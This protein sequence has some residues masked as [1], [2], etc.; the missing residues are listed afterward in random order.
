[1]YIILYNVSLK[2][3]LKIMSDP[4][5]V[6]SELEVTASEELEEEIQKELEEDL[7][8]VAISSVLD[9]KTKCSEGEGKKDED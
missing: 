7:P 8:E 6:E 3:G 1:V 5:F 9:E 2:R 4:K